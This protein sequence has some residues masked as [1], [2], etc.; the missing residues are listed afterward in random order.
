MST[1]LVMMLKSLGIDPKMLES[2]AMAVQ[3]AAGDLKAIKEQ[4]KQILET[5]EKILS[6]LNGSTMKVV[7]ALAEEFTGV[8][9]NV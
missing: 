8:G 6:L 7:Q 5:Q 3:S 4:Q 1:G 9:E 2:V